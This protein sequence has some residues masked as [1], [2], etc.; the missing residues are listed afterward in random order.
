[1][2]LL[3]VKM[4]WSIVSQQA[5][6]GA[7]DYVHKN[8]GTRGE[9][10]VNS[11]SALPPTLLDPPEYYTPYCAAYGNNAAAHPRV[12][13]VKLLDKPPHYL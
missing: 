8:T 10:G 5:I 6:N 11:S 2:E 13:Y 12:G 1:M 4:V 7:G 3:Y 9:Q